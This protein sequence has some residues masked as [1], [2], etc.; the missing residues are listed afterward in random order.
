MSFI[1]SKEAHAE[2]TK[3]LTTDRMTSYLIETK[4]DIRLAIR[5]YEKNTRLSEAMY[6]VL[7]GCE[8]A[9]RNSIH[10]NLTSAIGKQDWY[11]HIKFNQR[12][13]LMVGAAKLNL[14]RFKKK[15]TPGQVISELTMGFWIRLMAPE[16]EKALWVKHLHK[17]F[18]YYRKPD[19]VI[20]FARF[21]EIRR[22]RNR[23]AHHEPIF[24][25]DGQKEYGKVMEAV[26]WLCPVTS[27]WIDTHNNYPR[28][29]NFLR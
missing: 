23:I 15:V 22:L 17:A 2:L 5:L 18:P 4:G 29:V 16:Y 6:G 26:G 27:A 28:L 20:I 3:L 11:D 7:Q 1:Y 13:I 9:L 24:K 10:L 8:I 19:R 14:L 21:D 12:E 25:I